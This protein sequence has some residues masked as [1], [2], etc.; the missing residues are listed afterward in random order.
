MLCPLAV[1]AGNMADAGLELKTLRDPPRHAPCLY[2]GVS[3]N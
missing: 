1:V 3:H 2:I